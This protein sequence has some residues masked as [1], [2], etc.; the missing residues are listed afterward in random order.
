MVDETEKPGSEEQQQQQQP[1]PE[2]IKSRLINALADNTPP[3]ADPAP[4]DNQQQQQPDNKTVPPV[5]P[6]FSPVWN[7]LADK[8]STAEKPW[9]IP[10]HVKEGKFEEG[11][12]E[13]DH[14]LE[15][16]YQNTDFSTLKGYGDPLV[17]E[18]ITAAGQEN[19]DSDAWI[20][21]RAAN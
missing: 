10:V 2:E 15:V 12:T 17:Q 1:T 6:T 16:I 20:K 13:L 18:Y 21:S 14:I 4:G 11:K 7:Q 5:V 19:F 3:V 8:L 9:E